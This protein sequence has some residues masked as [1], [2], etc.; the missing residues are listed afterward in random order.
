MIRLFINNIEFTK[1]AAGIGE[2][3]EIIERNAEDGLVTYGTTLSLTANGDLYNLLYN[4][5]LKDPCSGREKVIEC[6][7]KLDSNNCQSIESFEIRPDS[8]GLRIDDCECDF[9]LIRVPEKDSEY[10]CLRNQISYGKLNGFK[11]YITKVD[12]AYKI[13]YCID[14]SVYRYMIIFLYT[15]TIKTLVDIIQTICN[16]INKIPFVDIDGCGAV[17]D[18]LEN[19][20]VGCNH[21]HTVA[22]IRDIM[23]Y[24]LGL[25][26]LKFKSSIFQDDP[27]YSM[28]ALESAANDDGFTVTQC[29]KSDHQWNEANTA[30]INAIQLIKLLKK[31]FNADAEIIG[32]TLYFERKDYFDKII[33]FVMNIE[34]EEENI[35]NEIEYSF[36]SE[37]VAAFLNLEYEQD[38]IDNMGNKL[39][40]RE[41]NYTKEWNPN[42]SKNTSG[43]KT[44][45]FDNFAAIRWQN[46]QY[47]DENFEAGQ[48]ADLR[49]HGKLLGEFNIGSCDFSH[50]QILSDGQFQYFKLFIIDKRPLPQ[51]SGCNFYTSSKT[52]IKPHVYSYNDHLKGKALYDRFHFIDDP[53]YRL[54]R[55]IQVDTIEWKPKDF[56]KALDII[57]KNNLNIN[58]ES[59]YYGEARPEKIEIDYQNCI[60][61]FTGMK[62][63]CEFNY[64]G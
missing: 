33:P 43:G 63:R 36:S 22:T 61:T 16:A 30:N 4:T 50:W 40:V 46:D 18:D 58:I 8:L 28:T 41:Y 45:N 47:S 38:P 62:Y 34:D 37:K 24:N 26:G 48:L 9:S 56:C 39:R 21:Y 29:D 15:T 20:I 59:K 44:I 64:P 17:F 3:K 19:Y 51:C 55:P 13:G 12:R 52:Y 49:A 6:K 23:E 32:D 54:I 11:D 10:E 27:A 57:R 2:L 14:L 42:K 1:Y 31:P 60:I 25:C 35:L 5:F 53:Q 7:V